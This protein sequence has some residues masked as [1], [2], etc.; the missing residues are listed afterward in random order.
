MSNYPLVIQIAAMMTITATNC[1]ITR[2]RISIC[3]RLALPPRIMFHK[4]R[5]NTMATREQNI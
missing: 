2:Q 4:P 1:R 5:N 3:D